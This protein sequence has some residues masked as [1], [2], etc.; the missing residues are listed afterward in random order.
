MYPHGD[1]WHSDLRVSTPAH[2][3]LFL[4]EGMKRKALVFKLLFFTFF[5]PPLAQG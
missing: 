3:G 4:L 1:I 5:C 2:W